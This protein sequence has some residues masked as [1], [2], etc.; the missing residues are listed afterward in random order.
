MIL[1]ARLQKESPKSPFST[2]LPSFKRVF[3][4]TMKPKSKLP[5]RDPP[6]YYGKRNTEPTHRVGTNP[7]ASNPLLVPPEWLF[8]KRQPGANKRSAD[9]L[10]P[11]AQPPAKRPALDEKREQQLLRSLAVKTR[12]L[13]I[14]RQHTAEA[15]Q[16][17]I[18]LN[19]S[20]K[21]MESQVEHLKHK[22]SEYRHDWRWQQHFNITQHIVPTHL[23]AMWRAIRKQGTQD[24]HLNITNHWPTRDYPEGR[25]L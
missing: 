11:A 5:K 9:F 8:S 6:I 17:S 24:G 21:K 15:Q 2:F 18:R 16:T 4:P 3:T 23:A 20:V 13:H 25:V 7:A 19:N 1:T 12:E 22:L 14:E 10:R